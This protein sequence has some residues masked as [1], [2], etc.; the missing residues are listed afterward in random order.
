MKKRAIFI[1]AIVI[2][3]TLMSCSGGGNGGSNMAALSVHF[4]PD[5][6]YIAADG[7]F[8][9]RVT[10][11]ENT[12]IG[13]E[14]TSFIVKFYTADQGAH[15]TQDLTDSFPSWFTACGGSGTYIPGGM[16]RCAD[17]CVETNA[18]YSHFT[19]T[20]RDDLGN[21]VGGSGRVDYRQNRSNS[22]SKDEKYGDIFLK[23]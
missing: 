11:T 5:P 3:G 19:F 20:G 9:F 2:V 13:V 1:L 7:R 6:V 23:P 21:S 18:A 15:S 4:V 10:V 22:H 14:I 12:G 16:S 17:I 8:Y